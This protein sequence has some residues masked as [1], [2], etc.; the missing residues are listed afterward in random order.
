MSKRVQCLH[1][2]E[3]LPV[4]PEADVPKLHI[5][6]GQPVFADP[7]VVGAVMV[8]AFEHQPMHAWIEGRDYVVVDDEMQTT[9][10]FHSFTCPRCGRTSH[11]PHDIEHG[12]CGNCHDVTGQS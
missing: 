6:P 5:G 9:T 10:T 2:L 4:G 12:Y 3:V 1:C 7:A 8:H 11:N